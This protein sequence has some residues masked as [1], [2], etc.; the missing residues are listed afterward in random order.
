MTILLLLLNQYA[1]H[2]LFL[3]YCIA[4]TSSTMWNKSGERE[5][6]FFVPNLIGSFQ[7][8]FLVEFPSCF[9][10]LG[11]TFIKFEKILDHYFN[12]SFSPVLQGPNY[13]KI[14]PLN[15]FQCIDTLFF[16]F[17]F[18]FFFSQYIILDNSCYY[19]SS[20]LISFAVFDLLL[21]L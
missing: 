13:R 16:F 15:P 9:F 5:H 11:F 2:F 12:F 6:P 17:F 3:S 14:R 1:I 19:I 18:Q 10:C 21:I 20:S 4:K 7:G 8:F